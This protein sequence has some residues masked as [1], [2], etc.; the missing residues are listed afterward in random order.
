MQ[1]IGLKIINTN[2]VSYKSISQ[3]LQ[4][5][6]L[7]GDY[8][9]ASIIQQLKNKEMIVLDISNEDHMPELEIIIEEF[10]DNDIKYQ[11]YQEVEDKWEEVELDDLDLDR[12]PAW[13]I[14]IVGVAFVGYLLFSFVE[15]FAIYDW[16]SIKYDIPEFFSAI[17]GVVT[18]FIPVVG[19]LVAYWSATELWH[20]DSL[21]TIVL[22][23]WYY[24]PVLFFIIYLIGMVLKLL[25]ADRWYRFRYPEFH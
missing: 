13:L 7:E 15:I 23:F 19:S 9:I 4:R 10:D 11:L 14:F 21:N 3:D 12:N 24:L 25:F 1:K 22:Y 20:W 16:Y 5:F 17:A 2:Y 8:S 18:A 6:I